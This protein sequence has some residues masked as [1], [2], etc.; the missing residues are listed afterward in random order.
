MADNL[1]DKSKGVLGRLV[2]EE[3]A[4]NLDQPFIYIES[5]SGDPIADYRGKKIADLSLGVLNSLVSAGFLGCYRAS[6]FSWRFTLLNPAYEAIKTDFGAAMQHRAQSVQSKENPMIQLTKK[7]KVFAR[8]LVEQARADD[9]TSPDEEFTCSSLLQDDDS[10]GLEISFPGSAPRYSRYRQGGRGLID[11]LVQERLL[12]E[13]NRYNYKIRQA[14]FDLVDSNFEEAIPKQGA[15]PGVTITELNALREA[16]VKHFNEDELKEICA[17]VGVDPE[18]ISGDTK[19]ARVRG[20]V[21]HMAQTG[22]LLNLVAHV[23]ATRPKLSW[24]DLLP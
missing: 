11:V 12:I 4:G 10:Q 9:P 3:E 6:P 13:T 7:E 15:G 17:K 23:G 1:R 22:R 16:M 21:Q 5:T 24:V 2:E 14:L 20:L 8:W 18:N 19:L